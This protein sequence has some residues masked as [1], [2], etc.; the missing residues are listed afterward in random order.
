MNNPDLI[1]IYDQVVAMENDINRVARYE[2]NEHWFHGSASGMCHRKN[3]YMTKEVEPSNPKNATTYRLLRSGTIFH[4]DFEKT[5]DLVESVMGGLGG[6][7]IN[8][9]NS[10]II[11]NTI[12]ELTS[13]IES[14]Q[15]EMEITLPEYNVRGFYDICVKMKTGEVYLYDVKT[16]NSWS[17]K[18]K[19]GNVVEPNPAI[20]HKLQLSTYG[21]AVEKEY[22]RLD[23]MFLLYKNKDT[24]VMKE[25]EVPLSFMTD[26]IQYWE[27]NRDTAMGDAPPMLED[28]VNPRY[29]W[30]CKYCDF[31]DYC[32]D[33]WEY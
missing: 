17:W 23:G 16:M 18:Y 19:F 21:L 25:V 12:I 1:G 5:K 7:T 24:S 8:S 30:E 9:S 15:T 20:H 11:Y 6:N 3:Y 28:D 33:D 22:G 14:Y 32:K 4:D 13:G 26:A 31:K 2:G 27:H 10:A 29:G